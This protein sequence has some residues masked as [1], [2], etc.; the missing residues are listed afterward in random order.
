[1]TGGLDS[2]LH[3]PFIDAVII[4]EIAHLREKHH[5]PAFWKLVYEMMPEYKDIMQH[6]KNLD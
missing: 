1:L 6:Q 3:S 4:H 2:A 5:Q